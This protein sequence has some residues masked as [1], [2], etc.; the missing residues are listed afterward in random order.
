MTQWLRD[1][2]KKLN[3]NRLER[4]KGWHLH[5]AWFKANFDWYTKLIQVCLQLI[6]SWHDEYFYEL[7]DISY[8]LCSFLDTLNVLITLM[9]LETCVAC[10]TVNAI[11]CTTNAETIY[12][13]HHLLIQSRSEHTFAP[14][15]VSIQQ[16]NMFSPSADSA[17]KLT[18]AS[19][20]FLRC[21]IFLRLN[22][23]VTIMK[24]K[25]ISAHIVALTNSRCTWQKSNVVLPL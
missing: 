20:W 16:P 25:S 24:I 13:I 15:L 6:Q 12:L 2:W 18:V 19:A 1:H 3:Y 7:N 22:Y 8:K 21:F 23:L 11:R 17:I 10:H 5:L 4:N 9:S 14:S